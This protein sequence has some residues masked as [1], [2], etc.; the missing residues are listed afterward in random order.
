MP[1]KGAGG[2]TEPDLPKYGKPPRVLRKCMERLHL[3]REYRRKPSGRYYTLEMQPE[4]A[5]KGLCE[6]G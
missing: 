5:S 3:H 6:Y 2:E 4:S 1:S